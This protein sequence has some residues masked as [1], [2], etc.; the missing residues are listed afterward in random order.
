M[1]RVNENIFR[2]YNKWKEGYIRKENKGFK[3]DTDYGVV[4]LKGEY[5]EDELDSD[6]REILDDRDLCDFDN[7]Q[8][9]KSCGEDAIERIK[10]DKDP[11]TYLIK[12]YK[13]GTCITF[14]PFDELTDYSIYDELVE[15]YGALDYVSILRLIVKYIRDNDIKIEWDKDDKEYKLLLYSGFVEDDEEE[16]DEESGWK[17]DDKI[18]YVFDE[19]ENEFDDDVSSWSYRD[20]INIGVRLNAGNLKYYEKMKDWVEG[21]LCKD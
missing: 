15:R 3:Y 12:N 21:I 11:Y 18:R 16:D 9:F 17:A 4:R 13:E 8:N 10:N 7:I 19:F 20:E 2:Q 14:R 6:I 5:D 1:D